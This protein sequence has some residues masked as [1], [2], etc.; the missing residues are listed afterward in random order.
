MVCINIQEIIFQCI[1]KWL[2]YIEGSDMISVRNIQYRRRFS[3]DSKRV[4]G[5]LGVDHAI[6]QAPMAGGITT[7]TLVSEVSNAGGLGMIAAGSLAPADLRGLIKETDEKTKKNFGVNL[8]VPKEFEVTE[9]EI[10]NAL[11]YLRPAY[12]AFDLKQGA[13]TPPAPKDITDK[14]EAY[15]EVIID[16]KVPVVSFIFGIPADDQIERL[17]NAGI[18]TLATATTAEEAAE[19]EAAGLDAVILQGSEAGGH[20]GAFLK[21]SKDSL[22]GL[23]SL[24]P[25]VVAQVDIPAIAAG[26]IMTGRHIAAAGILGAEGVQM[27]TA[28]LAAHES[29][30][31]PM[32][33]NILTESENVPAVLTTLYT[34]RQ[35]RAVKNKFISEFGRVQ[36]HMVEYPVQRSLTQPFQDASKE[37]GVPDYAMLLAGQSKQFARDMSARSLMESLVSEAREFNWEI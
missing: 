34:G 1:Y 30:A 12:E 3:M 13:I 7:S 18:V 20:R 4:S 37:S 27:G 28:F 5:L 29:G 10:S 11:E 33:K 31:H 19:I 36:E 8:F 26:G 14:F 15:I 35:A 9:S 32:H 22:V 17:K 2:I 24:I 25:E 6:I 16:E 23:M 21:H